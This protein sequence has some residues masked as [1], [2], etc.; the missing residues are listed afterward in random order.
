[1]SASIAIKFAQFGMFR[2]LILPYTAAIS[3]RSFCAGFRIS[4]NT[5]LLGRRYW[6][7]WYQVSYIVITLTGG[8]VTFE[9]HG[10]WLVY[11]LRLWAKSVNLYHGGV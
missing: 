11:S 5:E 3:E 1:M 7:S 6:N 2:A 4:N 10:E 9:A 8:K